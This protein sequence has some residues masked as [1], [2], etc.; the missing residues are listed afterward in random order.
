MRLNKNLDKKLELA[1]FKP[2]VVLMREGTNGKGNTTLFINCLECGGH[3]KAEISQTADNEILY[4]CHRCGARNGN[5]A[6]I[7]ADNVNQP[8]KDM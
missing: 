5:K 3:N 7:P 1:D 4:Y 2:Y 8:Y 6:D